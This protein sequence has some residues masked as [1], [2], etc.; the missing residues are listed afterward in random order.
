MRL[1]AANLIAGRTG[2]FAANGCLR[3]VRRRAGTRSEQASILI[4]VMWIAFGLV[5]LALYFAHS[6]SFELRAADNRVASTEADQAIAGAVR[7]VSNI[8]ATTLYPGALPEIETFPREAVEVGSARFW[9][10]G[11]ADEQLPPEEPFFNLVDECSKLNL[12]SVNTEM[13]EW[14]PRMLPEQAGAIQDWR[15]EDSD[16]NEIGGAEDDLY[17]R[18]NPSYQCKNAKFESLEELRLVYGMNLEV[19]LGEDANLNGVLDLN[20]NDGDQSFPFDNQDGRLDPGLFE[21]FTVYSKE[22][23]MRTNGSPRINV[24]TTNQQDLATL[25]A[26][27]FDTEKANQILAGFSTGGE[28]VGSLLEF[29]IRSGMTAQDFVQIETDI[30]AT[31]NTTG[32]V[33]VNTASERVLSCIPGIGIEN[34]PALVA[35]R[36]SNRAALAVEP[37]LA[38][39]ADVLGETNAVQA[40]PFLTGRSFQYTADIAAVGHFGRGFRRVKVV[41]DTSQGTPRV[42]YR[43]DITHLGW[44]LGRDIRNEFLL[45]ARNKQ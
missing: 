23:A 21:Y 19:L 9:L 10:I 34:A 25:L 11:R 33:N 15:D 27:K 31:T 29:Y 41:F 44:A 12:N 14:I 3:T 42:I 35:H 30:T 43:R 28:T 45:L 38:W 5:S 36:R 22:P 24:A 16:V 40:G 39:V 4:I 8:L 37:T 6:M 2:P 26:E 20:E 18:L 1:G 7:Y 32:L 13:L 17:Q